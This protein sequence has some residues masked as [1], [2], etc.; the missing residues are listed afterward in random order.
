MR[1]NKNIS[2]DEFIQTTHLK[3]P[4]T[5]IYSHLKKENSLY[6]QIFFKKK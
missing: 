2:S 3:D 5:Q 1:K 4:E 6:S